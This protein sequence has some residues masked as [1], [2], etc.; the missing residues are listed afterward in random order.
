MIN[1]DP[2]HSLLGALREE[3][4]LTG[5]YLYWPRSI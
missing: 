3:L 5:G 4:R 1:T 2:D